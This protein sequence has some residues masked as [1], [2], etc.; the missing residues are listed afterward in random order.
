M[1]CGNQ[2]LDAASGETAVDCGGAECAKRCGLGE[3]CAAA[4]DCVALLPAPPAHD[5]GGCAPHAPCNPTH[6]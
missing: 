3:G 1:I 2:A 4:G 5:A 6:A